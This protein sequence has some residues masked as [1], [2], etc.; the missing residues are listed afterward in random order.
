MPDFEAVADYL[1]DGVILAHPD[2]TIL[3]ANPAMGE[4]T[5]HGAQVTG[6]SFLALYSPAGRAQ[7]HEY[8][9]PRMR[10]EGRW[11]GTM[12]MQRADGV[13]WT[14]QINSIGIPDP[15]TGEPVWAAT[16]RDITQQQQLEAER[17]LLQQQ[18]IDA[19][20]AALRDLST[21]LLPI[22]DGLLVVP[23]IGV[24]DAQRAA[25]MIEVVLSGVVTHAATTVII[26]ITGMPFVDTQTGDALIHTARAVRLLG[27]QIILTGIRPE[28]AQVL[29]TL[30]VDF[31][32]IITQRTLQEGVAYVLKLTHV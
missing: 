26:D 9:I 23:I 28:V 12:E 29:H 4:M 22:A 3:Y 8:E 19:Q 31:Q 17:Q 7:L 18:V 16:F 24:L 14:A 10:A 32:G 30:G 15:V 11:V 2:T 1:L 13:L 25:D 5:G 20:Q 21:P 6:M 27:A